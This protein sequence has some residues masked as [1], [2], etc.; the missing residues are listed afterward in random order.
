MVVVWATSP[1]AHCCTGLGECGAATGDDV[2]LFFPSSIKNFTNKIFFSHSMQVEKE[3]EGDS[4]HRRKDSS[5]SFFSAL[6][7]SSSMAFN[8]FDLLSSAWYEPK[9]IFPLSKSCWVSS[10][11]FS[12]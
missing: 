6:W 2:G 8:S 10:L 1:I 11:A 3:E 7:S 9:T 12:V 5:S 4:G